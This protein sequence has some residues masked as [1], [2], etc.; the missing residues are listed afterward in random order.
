MAVSNDDL[1]RKFAGVFGQ[2]AQG[3][4][5]KI[6]VVR[7]PGRVNLIG[8]HTD[9]NDGFVFPMAIEPEVRLACRTREDA[10]IRL[11]ST[12]YPKQIV[13][14][15][16]SEKIKP[17][18]PAW[19]NYSKGVAAGLLG[20]GIPLVGMDA[21]VD[22]TLPIG[23]GLS[24]SAAIEI[25]TG[26]ALLALAGVE[27]DRDRLALLCQK[28]E[29]EYAGAPV[30]IMDQTIVASAKAGHAMVLDCRDKSKRFVPLDDKELR[31]VIA[32]SMVKHHLVSGEYAARR[33]QCEQGVA[34]FHQSNPEVR[35]LRDV[36]V[37]QVMAAKGKLPDVV[38][39]RCHHVVTENR[40]T[41]EAASKLEQKY[42]EDVGALMLESHQSLRDDYEVSVPEL[43]FLVDESMKVKGVYGARM[44]G[45]GFG[46]C[47]VALVQ[48]RAAESLA[49]HLTETYARKYS[50]KPEVF[51]TTATAGACLL[52]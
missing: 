28:A 27:M 34:F 2:P 7:A 17:G 4:A 43:D 48:P 40:R 23:G 14:F 11:S 19:A 30:G 51:A 44:T 32:N 9:Y 21:L 18:D 50:K 5:A 37:S 25:S 20:A 45:G 41:Q 31:I 1:K 8:E 33:K 46:G 12:A 10:K 24:S 42:Y 15:S 47:I 35:A 38:W 36:T 16:L 3:K 29:H 6:H 39:R 52:E 13:E 26:L 22:N 49:Q